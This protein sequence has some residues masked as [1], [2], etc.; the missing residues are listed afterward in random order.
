M[1]RNIFILYKYRTTKMSFDI[2]EQSFLNPK[3]HSSVLINMVTEQLEENKPP[4]N[5][6]QIKQ[7]YF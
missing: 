2:F 7:N 3:V 1:A 4:S 6:A 5:I